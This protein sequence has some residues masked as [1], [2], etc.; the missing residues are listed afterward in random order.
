[1]W[2]KKPNSPCS[3]GQQTIFFSQA[4]THLC[5]CEWIT[6]NRYEQTLFFF[7]KQ[8]HADT[9]YQMW[10]K[11]KSQLLEILQHERRMLWS[12]AL[13]ELQSDR[14]GG[15]TDCCM[16]L[17]QHLLLMSFYCLY[18]YQSTSLSQ[19]ILFIIHSVLITWH[20]HLFACS[21]LIMGATHCVVLRFK[22]LNL[23]Q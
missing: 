14:F 5:M 6:L 9:F 4:H 17:C 16:C 8:F 13:D 19:T 23:S 11:L 7:T 22:S 10:H 3:L 12:E 18:F 15:F 2:K 1:M 20:L 21:G